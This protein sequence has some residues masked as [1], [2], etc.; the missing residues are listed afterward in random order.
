[1]STFLNILAALAL[2]LPLPI[3]AIHEHRATR[4][5]AAASEEH[6]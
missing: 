4:A 3:L 2:I 6:Q 1:M 5:E